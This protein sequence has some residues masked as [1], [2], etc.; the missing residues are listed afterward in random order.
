MKDTQ[1]KSW[2]QL[3]KYKTSTVYGQKE[4]LFENCLSQN[5]THTK[6]TKYFFTN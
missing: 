1:G 5:F 2:A 3:N 4:E 6:S